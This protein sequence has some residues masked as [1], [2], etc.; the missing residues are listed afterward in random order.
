MSNLLVI[1][2]SSESLERSD[3]LII[4]MI[5]EILFANYSTKTLHLQHKTYPG[6]PKPRLFTVGRLDV[7]TTGLIIVTNDG[8]LCKKLLMAASLLGLPHKKIRVKRIDL[9]LFAKLHCFLFSGDFAQS[10]S[11]PSS[12]ISKE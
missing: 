4:I 10:I 9:E 11:H 12:G 1:T 7:A 2:T 3:N 8:M 5:H 6:Q